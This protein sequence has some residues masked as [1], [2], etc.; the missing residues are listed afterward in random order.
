MM[1]PGRSS[2]HRLFDEVGDA[3]ELGRRRTCAA[4]GRGFDLRDREVHDVDGVTPTRL[5]SSSRRDGGG[6]S[7]GQAGAWRLVVCPH[8]DV[9]PA[10]YLIGISSSSPA[11]RNAVSRVTNSGRN[12]GRS[13]GEVGRRKRPIPAASAASCSHSTGPDRAPCSAFDLTSRDVPHARNCPGSTLIRPHAV[14]RRRRPRRGAC[15]VPPLLAP[16]WGR[17]DRRS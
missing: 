1:R 4:V 2:C 3:L 12:E 10:Q 11:A 8:R 16:S 13:V 5:R 14:R 9:E 17:R 6:S 15:D 7:S